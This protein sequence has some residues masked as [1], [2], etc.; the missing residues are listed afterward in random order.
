M[1]F[2]HYRTQGIFLKKEERGETDRLFTIFSKDYGKLEILGR[3]IRKITSKL[4]SG[5]ELFYLSEIEFVQGKTYKVL[6]D[7]ILI[8]KFKDLREN[9]EKLEIAYRIT[10]TLDSLTGSEERDDKIWEILNES[11]QKIDNLKLEIKNSKLKIIYYYFLWNLFSLLG[12]RP[13]LYSCPVCQKKLLPET[14]YFSAKEGGVVCWRCLKNFK[15]EDKKQTIPVAVETIKILR[16]LLTPLD[17]KHLTGREEDWKILERLK[18]KKKDLDD[19]EEISKFYLNFL[20][21]VGK[22]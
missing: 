14:F 4:R 15:E 20:N 5:A 21:P 6:T 8:E 16:I 13:E 11:F 17:S 19:L 9:P 12:Y 7:A 1:P 22:F 2:T 18:I 10:D 3:A